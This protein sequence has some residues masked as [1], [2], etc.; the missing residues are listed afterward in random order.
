LQ[1]EKRSSAADNVLTRHVRTQVAVLAFWILRIT[2][3]INPPTRK[4]PFLSLRRLQSVSIKEP[5]C[6]I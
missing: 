1:E 6:P 3:E 2:G 4:N 5:N